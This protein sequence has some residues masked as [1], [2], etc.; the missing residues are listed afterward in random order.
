MVTYTQGS[1]G[2]NYVLTFKIESIVSLNHD[3]G[4]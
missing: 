1:Q 2:S 3:R 4:C